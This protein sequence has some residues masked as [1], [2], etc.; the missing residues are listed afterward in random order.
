MFW[1]CMLVLGVMVHTISAQMKAKQQN[2]GY[3]EIVVLAHGYNLNSIYIWNRLYIII[4][5][6]Q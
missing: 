3:E 5:F 6:I 4:L 1:Q 2:L